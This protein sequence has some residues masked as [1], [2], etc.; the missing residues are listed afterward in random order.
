MV[1]NFSKTK[2]FKLD[3]KL[4]N[5]TLEVVEETKLL[6]VHIT[7]DLRW[8][9]NTELLVK[10]A[11]RRMRV[12]HKAAKF[13]DNVLDLLV[14]YKTFIRSKLEQ[15]AA[16]W[17]SSLSKDN[18]ADLERVQKSALKII[19]KE[20]YC[21]YKDALRK[22]NI[23]SLYDRREALLLRFA[24]KSLKLTQFRKLFPVK[25]QLH[26]MKTRNHQKFEVNSA[27]TERYKKSS[28][29]AMQRLL[30]DYDRSF[31]SICNSLYPV[32][33]EICQI[34]SLVEKI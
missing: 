18:E 10:D 26:S 25:K 31:K 5:E 4:K 16:V 29:P 24:K 27:C 7:S 12:L 30:N 17:H 13:T 3:V 34:G 1:F 28:V 19:L 8:N 20:R 15:S 23:E 22:L 33:N 32:T 14:I 9:K 2:Q 21:N 6:G 11:N